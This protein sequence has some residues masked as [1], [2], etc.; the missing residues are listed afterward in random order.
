MSDSFCEEKNRKRSE[1]QC[2]QIADTGEKNLVEAPLIHASQRDTVDFRD[3][4]IV[5]WL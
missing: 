1:I 2:N 5:S 4:V 3:R